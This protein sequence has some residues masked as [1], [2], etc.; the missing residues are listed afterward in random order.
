VATKKLFSQ[1]LVKQVVEKQN[2]EYTAVDFALRYFTYFFHDPAEGNLTEDKVKEYTKQFQEMVG[3]E[4]NGDLDTKTVR[5]M[6]FM[7]RCGCKD[8][9]LISPEAAG[10]KSWKNG[11]TITYFVE[12]YV[13]GLSQ[14]DQDDLIALGFQQWADVADLKFQRVNQSFQ[15]NIIISTG[16][17]AADQ[18][19][20]P[21]GTLAWAYL[22]PQ[23]NFQ[24]QLLMRFDMDET[25]IK[26]TIDRGVLYLNVA[27]HEFGHLLGL[28]HSQNPKALMAPYY[29]VG[30]TKPQ[31]QDDIPRIQAIYGAP[32]ATAA[33]ATATAPPG[34]PPPA[35]KIKVEIMVDSLSDIKIQGKNVQDF[36]LI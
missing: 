15:A 6:E 17:G 9:S 10:V 36:A 1:K 23:P 19:D 2:L 21:A 29:A 16:C 28:E 25:W 12:K 33:A 35:G 32:P 4:A 13:G 34:N 22:P 26:S 27:T 14:S 31:L 30:I 18:F 24:G 8:F 7:P 20:G 3:I 5:A 11:M